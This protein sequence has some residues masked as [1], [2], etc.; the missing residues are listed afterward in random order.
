[1]LKVTDAFN[2]G[3]SLEVFDFG[4]PIGTT[5]PVQ[6]GGTCNT[7]PEVCFADPLSSSA[8]FNLGPGDH[9]ITINAVVTEFGSGAAYFRVDGD[10]V[11]E[12]DFATHYVV[13]SIRDGVG[14]NQKAEIE[15]Q[16]G[17]RVL[18][19]GREK[20]FVVPAIK[21]P[22]E[23]PTCEPEVCGGYTFTCDPNNPG[24]T[25]FKLF[26]GSGFCGTSVSCDQPQCGPN[27]ECP[28]GSVCQVETCCGVPICVSVDTQC[29]GGPANSEPAGE[30]PTTTSP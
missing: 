11:Q 4:V 5:P 16:F 18:R 29:N 14:L 24:C 20:I 7:D 9:S 6:S 19:L 12:G 30:G 13:Y 26:D 23:P 25:C 1:V 15:D 2:Y 21:N 8:T 17:R 3:D 10:Q 27:G 28:S 22:S